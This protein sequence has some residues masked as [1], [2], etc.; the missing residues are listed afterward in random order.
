MSR[1]RKS[2]SLT[3][4]QLAVYEELKNGPRGRASPTLMTFINCPDLLRH[5]QKLGFVVRY[6]SVLPR[7]VTELAILVTARFWNCDA[8]WH[9]HQP[10]ALKEGLPLDALD[11]IRRRTTPNFIDNQDQLVYQICFELF[12][13]R[14]VTEETYAAGV[15][16]FG[17]SGM[18][19]LVAILGYYSTL[20]LSLKTF[21]LKLP[22]GVT[23]PFAAESTGAHE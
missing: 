12:E 18:T 15:A 9:I 17:E 3:D 16:L 4:E 6:N 2:T 7:R 5:I 22:E 1:L 11:S 8:E 10:L 20:A 23:P 21:D 14:T 19:M 13:T